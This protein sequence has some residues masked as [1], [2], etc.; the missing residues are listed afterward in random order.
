VITVIV[1]GQVRLCR[2]GIAALL[3]E[4]DG[5]LVVGSTHSSDENTL[6][7][8]TAEVLVLDVAGETGISTVRH[9][10]V[11]DATTKVVAVGVPEDEDTIMGLVEAGVCGFVLEE[12]NVLA[13]AET[14]RSAVRGEIRCSPRLAAALA[15]RVNTLAAGQQRVPSDA[16]LTARELQIVE[17]IDDGLS[18]KEIASVLRIEV[19]TVKNHVHNVLEKLHVSRRAEAAARVRTAFRERRSDRIQLL[20]GGVRRRAVDLEIHGGGSSA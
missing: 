15:R 7:A 16:H 6:E 5:L 10:L 11:R 12:E 18:N 2:E 1:L 19:A 3:S 13:L 14:L 20:H 8:V 4:Q 17:L 9:L